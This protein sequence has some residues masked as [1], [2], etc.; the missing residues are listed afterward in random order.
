MNASRTEGAVS[1]GPGRKFDVAGGSGW[2][3][4]GRVDRVDGGEG[5]VT[6]DAETAVNAL[7]GGEIDNIDEPQID[8][9]KQLADDK[10]VRIGS[11][12]E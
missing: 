3:G 5:V 11:P 1:T 12:N 2:G 6:P 8:L 4:G 7:A 10:K 9:L